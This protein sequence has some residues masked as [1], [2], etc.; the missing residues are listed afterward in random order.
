MQINQIN[1]KK[2]PKFPHNGN[3]LS[4][5]LK[6]K[7]NEYFKQNN[8]SPNGD[9]SLFF[10]AIL[11]VCL[12]VLI[13]V[14]LV[15]FTPNVYVSIFEC[16]FLGIIIS[17]IGFNVLH[18][19][20]H[21]SFSKN[22]FVN[23]IAASSISLLGANHFMWNMKH[24]M[25]HHTYT[26]IDGMDD[27][28]D[29]GIFMRMA[30]NQKK[31]KLHA[32]QHYYFWF[33]Y[34]FL[35]MFWIFFSDYQKYFSKKIGTI[36]LKKM[37]LKHHIEFWLIKVYHFVF[38]V[39]IPIFKLGFIKWMIGFFI[40]CAVAGFILSIV[41]QLAHTIDKTLFPQI[42]ITSNLLKND[43]AT[44]QI[45]TTANFAT[46]NKIINWLV[47]GLNFQI[48]HHLFPKISHIHYPKIS[49]I[50]K[51]VCAQCDLQYNEYKTTRSAIFAHIKFLKFMGQGLAY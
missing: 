39:I 30:P 28:I 41:F 13:Y 4:N 5:E 35:Y 29:I 25:I 22:R 8:I 7:V 18:D 34:M 47:G 42:D 44:H 26:N 24:N 17:C 21:G 36:P 45:L 11:F 51:E 43:Y 46:H 2:L 19:G 32:I 31:Y 15:F 37:S 16:I 23:K 20:S 38:F 40:I 1:N 48:E 33:L 3:T 27:D 10:K 49:K 50:V 14:H 6:A 12:F 9:F